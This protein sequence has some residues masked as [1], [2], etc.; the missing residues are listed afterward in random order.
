MAPWHLTSRLHFWCLSQLVHGILFCKTR[1]TKMSF[2]SSSGK[3]LLPAATTPDS[4]LDDEEK[5][6][7]LFLNI[8]QPVVNGWPQ[9]D[10]NSMVLPAQQ[11]TRKMGS[12]WPKGNPNKDAGADS[13]VL[14]WEWWKCWKPLRTYKHSTHYSC[15]HST[16]MGSLNGIMILM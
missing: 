14:D 10:V 16:F 7:G 8:H 3:S 12:Q 2:C 4:T 1:L 13:W 15:T 5:R 9:E 6:R 11:C